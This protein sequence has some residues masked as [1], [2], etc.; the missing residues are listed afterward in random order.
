MLLEET[1]PVA[2]RHIAKVQAEHDDQYLA[3]R[4][5]AQG[6][7]SALKGRTGVHTAEEF[8]KLLEKTRTDFDTGAFLVERW[9]PAALSTQN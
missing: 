1:D 9:E 8:D 5:R 6:M 4:R 7:F 2:Q 3:L